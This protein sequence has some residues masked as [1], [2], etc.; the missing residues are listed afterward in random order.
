MQ[1]TVLNSYQKHVV[2]LMANGDEAQQ[3]GISN[4]LSNY[5]AQ[6]AFDTADA[7]W[8]S[9]AIGENTIEEWKREHMRTPYH[10]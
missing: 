6:K 1:T 5:F 2:D 4:L 7:L 9:G 3:A 8:N 10:E